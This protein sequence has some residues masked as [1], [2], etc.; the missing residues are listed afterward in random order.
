MISRRP[1]ASRITANKSVFL[2]RQKQKAGI[3]NNNA[4]PNRGIPVWKNRLCLYVS[5][6]ISILL[7]PFLSP[8]L[9]IQRRKSSGAEVPDFCRDPA[10]LSTGNLWKKNPTLLNMR[11]PLSIHLIPVHRKET[12]PN[13]FSQSFSF[14]Q[15]TLFP[16][17]YV[18]LSSLWHALCNQAG[19]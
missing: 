14:Y 9:Q 12:E 3:R 4:A 18:S 15:E 8:D 6:F 5:F 1:I 7:F 13:N 19:S 16:T 17:V 11:F 10:T 2:L